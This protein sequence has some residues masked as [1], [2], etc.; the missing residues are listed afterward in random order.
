MVQADINSS[1][2]KWIV[3]LAVTEMMMIFQLRRTIQTI[4]T[5]F[6]G[7]EKRDF[8]SCSSL[9]QRLLLIYA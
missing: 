2:A 3:V 8:E 1:V 7:L 5:A 4:E 9:S 6:V